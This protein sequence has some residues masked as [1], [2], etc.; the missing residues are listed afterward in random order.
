MYILKLIQHITAIKWF[1]F[2]AVSYVFNYMKNPFL[3]MKYGY[4]LLIDIM[5]SIIW[6]CHLLCVY[7]PRQSVVV[8]FCCLFCLLLDV[9]VNIVN[10]YKSVFTG[11]SLL[12][13]RLDI[14]VFSC[15]YIHLYV[16]L[17][18]SLEHTCYAHGLACLQ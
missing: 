9:P 10:N 5:C 12:N 15:S 7:F 6:R 14:A 1:F 18:S 17:N 4:I 2:H 16:M 8:C 13:C 11:I 3:K